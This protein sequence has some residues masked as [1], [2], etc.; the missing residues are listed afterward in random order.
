MFLTLALSLQFITNGYPLKCICQFLVA[1][2]EP[3]YTFDASLINA[4][5]KKK[6]HL[7]FGFQGTIWDSKKAFNEDCAEIS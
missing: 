3:D 4:L 7:K 1:A 2:S 6:I 5:K